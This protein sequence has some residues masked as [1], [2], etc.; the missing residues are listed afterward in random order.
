MTTTQVKTGT[1]AIQTPTPDNI[2]TVLKQLKEVAEVGQRLRGDP[3]TSFVRVSDLVS[4]NMA[5]LV[6]GQLKP[7]SMISVNTIDS[8][9]GGG[10]VS[11]SLTLSLVGDTV[12][13]GNSMLYGTNS[14]G[15]RGWYAQSGAGAGGTVTS[16]SAGTGLTGGTITTSGTIAL[17]NTAVTPGSYTNATVTVDAQ[18]RLTA[19]STG[20]SGANP[21]ATVSGTAVNGTATT[22]MRS[23]A[24]PALANTAV[25]PGS[26]TNTNLTV[27]AQGRITAAA[28]G[29]AGGSGLPAVPGNIPNLR[30]W[31]ATDKITEPSASVVSIIPSANPQR[32]PYY[33]QATLFPAI[34]VTVDSGTLNGLPVLA[35]PGTANGNYNLSSSVLLATQFTIFAVINPLTAGV[36]Q[37]LICGLQHAV[38]FQISTTQKLVLADSNTAVLATSTGSLTASTYQQVMCQWTNSTKAYLFHIARTAAGSGT[39]SATFASTTVPCSGMFYN[40]QAS[41]NFFNGKFAEMLCYDRVLTSLEITAVESY[42]LGKWGV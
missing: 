30:L 17:A 37:D 16:V 3:L 26:Y 9:S 28:S 25:A 8:L 14:S 15:V 13:P 20:T 24:A 1:T 7:P 19:A 34:G 32:V 33:A 27:D 18:G 23:D 5:R 42:L 39:G 4:N 40:V 29:S 41:A 21:S 22:F 2:Q 35:C 36:A 10:S 38:D 11:Q 12:T 31:L 6:N